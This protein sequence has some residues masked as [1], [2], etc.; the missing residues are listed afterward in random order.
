MARFIEDPLRLS[1]FVVVDCG[2]HYGSC[3]HAK[4]N[5]TARVVTTTG[6]R[7]SFD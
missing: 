4:N 7:D 3:E 6:Q 2:G 1:A 5:T